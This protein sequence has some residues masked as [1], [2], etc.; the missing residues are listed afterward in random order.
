M[1]NHDN[2]VF[3]PVLYS[4]LLSSTPVVYYGEGYVV[5]TFHIH[6]PIEGDKQYSFLHL[7]ATTATHGDK[8]NIYHTIHHCR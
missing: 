4:L 7:V 8:P 1:F 5:R 6:M 3:T 2:E